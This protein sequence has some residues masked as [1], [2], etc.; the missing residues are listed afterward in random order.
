MFF[1]T[2][3][4]LVSILILVTVQL[5]AQ[6]HPEIKW[7]EMKQEDII[8]IFPE[9][10]EET[11]T[12]TLKTA[13]DL[14]DRL[15][16]FWKSPVKRKTRIVLTDH[17]DNANG[18]T[19]FFP[20]NLITIHLHGPEPDS[21]MGNSQDWITL[22]L[23]HELSHLF[24]FHMGSRFIKWMRNIF[25][26]NPVLYPMTF[27]PLWMME[28]LAIYGESVSDPGGRLNTPDFNLF[29]NSQQKEKN[30]PNWNRI[31]G[32]RTLWPGPNSPY[33]YGSTFLSY[34]QNNHS[35]KNIVDFS[36]F[37]S[38]P[39]IILSFPNMFKKFYGKK[40]TALWK[41][42][43]ES[44]LM[45]ESD[46]KSPFLMSTDSG[47]YH[48]FPVAVAENKILFGGQDYKGYPGIVQWD[49]SGNKEKKLINRSRITAM[50]Y[51]RDSQ[52]VYF[53]ANDYFKTYYTYSDIYT[54]D[55]KRKTPRRLTR[56]KRLS[57]PVRHGPDILCIQ[58]KKSHSYLC[59]YSPE[60]KTIR[61]LSQPFDTMAFVAVS[62]NQKHIAASI[63]TNGKRW[64]IGIFD[65]SGNLLKILRSSDRKNYHPRWKTD[66]E[67]YFI[68]QTKN[69]YRLGKYIIE[70]DT[71][72]IQ[73]SPEL[74]AVQYFNWSWN[75]KDL[76]LTVFSPKGYDLGILPESEISFKPHPSITIFQS[77]QD[78][79]SGDKKEQPAK[80]TG[81]HTLRDLIPQYVSPYGRIFQDKFQ[82]GILISGQD[83]L[84]KHNYWIEGYGDIQN[85]YINYS[86]EYVYSGMFPSLS[87]YHSNEKKFGLQSDSDPFDWHIREWQFRSTFP[88]KTR[89]NHQI[90]GYAS[91]HLEKFRQIFKS[92]DKDIMATEYNGIRFGFIFNTAKTYWD[93]ISRSD[94]TFLNFGF[95]R[96]LK[97]LGSTFDSNRAFLVWNQYISIFRPGVLALRF[98]LMESW[99]ES[100][101]ITLMGGAESN[102]SYSTGGGGLFDV[103]RGYPDGYFIGSGGALINA[104]CRIPLFKLE[105]ASLLGISLERFYLTLFTDIGNLWYKKIEWDPSFSFGGELSLVVHLGFQFTFTGGIAWSHN[106]TLDP[107]FYFRI[108]K[109]F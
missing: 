78:H 12:Q 2:K 67:L 93:S 66:N 31:F 108:G 37:Y 14:Y 26:S 45:R 83:A 38:K 25:G 56:G 94:G 30:I 96:D 34:L 50:S 92:T 72:W 27:S 40:L 3:A 98:S 70:E 1:R 18:S 87:I 107:A 101:Y 35:G 29:L 54:W 99:G 57:Y 109:S 74:P 85:K 4:I 68:S 19:T 11:A 60:A 95:H 73:D 13:C 79:S 103:M 48:R 59:R 23:S 90:Y 28:G 9:G 80:T 22:V 55:L 104:E 6:Y 100:E 106:P 21:Y 7:R 20:L 32:Q 102:T 47:Y 51:D 44:Y 5:N 61:I 97:W 76:I 42:Y 91:L 88:I 46:A 75:M 52:Q 24:T 17:T 84:A 36:H 8:L 77:S 15:K 82:P 65:I 16:Q 62:P 39:L 69:A 43:Q 53:S 71:C 105:L 41:E 58:R 86:A 63:K 49:T 81:Y 33:L 10:Y 89:N 64:G